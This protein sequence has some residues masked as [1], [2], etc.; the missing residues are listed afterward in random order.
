MLFLNEHQFICVHLAHPYSHISDIFF[1]GTTFV[2]ENKAL[3]YKYV[4]Y[5][6]S[7]MY[8]IYILKCVLYPFPAKA[9]TGN[10]K[11]DALFL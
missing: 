11:Q 5:K 4:E 8:C 7:L 1:S 3:H 10:Q 6:K 2:F 9:F